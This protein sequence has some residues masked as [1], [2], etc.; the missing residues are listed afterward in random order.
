MINALFG[1]G[2]A[3]FTVPAILGT[4]VFVV[5]IA[6][7]LVG[8]D[9]EG[10]APTDFDMMDGDVGLDDS[11]DAF[12]L[13]SIQSIAAFLM[14]FGWAGF[15]ASE[16]FHW[17]LAASIAIGAVFGAFLVWV[18]GLMLKGIH[19]LQS[20]GNVSIQ[21]ALGLE[22]DVYASIPK[23]GAGAGQ[24]RLILNERQ[25]IYG[26]V[27]DEGPIGR[28]ERIRVTRINDDNTVTVESASR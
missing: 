17:S 5:Q 24:V 19:D 20:S 23:R 28:G 11:G 2:A 4:L 3:W 10:D 18:L 22:G 13:L 27:S 7:M 8:A 16:G 6:L 9:L 26:A 15:A 25:R 21:S 14:G 1:N 12:E